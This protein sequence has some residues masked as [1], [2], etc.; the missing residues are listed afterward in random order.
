MKGCVSWGILPKRP[1]HWASHRAQDLCESRDGR[2]GLGSL[3]IRTVSGR[4]ATW[5]STRASHNIFSDKFQAFYQTR[6]N[7]RA[8]KL[9]QSGYFAAHNLPII[10]LKSVN[11]AFR[12]YLVE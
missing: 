12:V 2:P 11:S 5:N 8:C 1:E 9:A 3:I 10:L 7:N 4:K 6:D